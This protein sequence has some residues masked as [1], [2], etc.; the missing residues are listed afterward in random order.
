MA[1]ELARTSRRDVLRGS[2]IGVGAL[3][4]AMA[5]TNSSE[6]AAEAAVSGVS[7]DMTVGIIGATK[8]KLNSLAF[9][10]DKPATG[11]AIPEPLALTIPTGYHSTILLQA[12]ALQSDLGT[13]TIRGYSPDRSGVSVNTLLITCAHGR[14]GHYH[15]SASSGTP[16][17]SVQLRFVSVDLKWVPKGA[18]YTWTPPPPIG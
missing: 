4:G 1:E 11:N 15:L 17:D 13:V 14:V 7:Y 9:G 18:H 16:V 6:V 10:G 5:L 3:V 2:A 8:I 12:F